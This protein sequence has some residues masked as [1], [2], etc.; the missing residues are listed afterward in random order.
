MI[1][2]PTRGN[3]AAIR[4]FL[5][6]SILSIMAAAQAPVSGP[7][8]AIVIRGELSAGQRF[9]KAINKELVF[10][11]E[12]Q[13]LGP[14]GDL[15]GWEVSLASSTNINRDYIYPVNPPLRFNGM[16]ILGPSYG[17]NTQ[18][19]LGHP[20]RMRFLLSKEDDDRLWPLVENALWPYSAPDPD[21]AADQYVRA[22]E[23]LTTG[24]LNL[25]VLSYTADPET[26]SVRHIRFRAT[27]IAPRSF[28]F[29]NALMPKRS[30]CP[31]RQN[32]KAAI[33]QR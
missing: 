16:Q 27:F 5:L 28:E 30:S 6:V 29:H 18:N 3:T 15:N 9:E 26:G 32:S 8:H 33:I 4:L 13:H 17:E 14:K 31:D 24:E 7:C 25:T 20:H 12:P 10:R 2:P 21:K 19:S 1:L 22:L 11:M 23:S